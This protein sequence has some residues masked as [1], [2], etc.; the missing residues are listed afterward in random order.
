MD[1]ELVNRLRQFCK[2]KP[3]NIVQTDFTRKQT[4]IPEPDAYIALN[5]TLQ[6]GIPKG[7]MLVITR[8]KKRPKV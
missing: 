4:L 1:R 6:G 5:K 7:E 3:V 2:D 8:L